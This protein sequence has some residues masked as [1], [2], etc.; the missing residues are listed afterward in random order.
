MLNKHACIEQKCPL[1]AGEEKHV[2]QHAPR[3][4]SPS[5]PLPIMISLPKWK[6]GTGKTVFA[7]MPT[8]VPPLPC[9]PRRGKRNA[10]G[11]A[12]ADANG[13]TAPRRRSRQIKNN[14][15]PPSGDNDAADELA[16]ADDAVDDA[17]E[18]AGAND[19][20]VSVAKKRLPAE[21]LPF[22]EAVCALLLRPHSAHQS[23]QSLF[24]PRGARR[25]PAKLAL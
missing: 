10:A 4:Q 14:S 8:S 21:V 23:S 25:R 11:S 20:D 24:E 17:N 13:A 3:V 19:G 6:R 2:S 1:C 5:P 15:D 16:I 12:N 7:S 9:R 18:S 22:L